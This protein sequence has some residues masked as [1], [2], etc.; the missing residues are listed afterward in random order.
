MR[1]VTEETDNS[2]N[3][4]QQLGT[5]RVEEVSGM[6]GMYSMYNNCTQDAN[7]SQEPKPRVVRNRQSVTVEES[8]GFVI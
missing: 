6:Y 4:L 2:S 7:Y 3:H 5:P 8:K 1:V